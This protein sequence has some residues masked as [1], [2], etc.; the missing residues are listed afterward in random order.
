MIICHTMCAMKGNPRLL[1]PSG[2][3]SFESHGGFCSAKRPSDPSSFLHHQKLPL[4]LTYQDGGG[5]I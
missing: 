5:E 3:Q 1:R 2:E 4:L